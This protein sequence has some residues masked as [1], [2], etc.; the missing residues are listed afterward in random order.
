MALGAVPLTTAAKTR[1]TL[2]ERGVMMQFAKQSPILERLKLRNIG[3]RDY[4]WAR[5]TDNVTGPQYGVIGSG[6]QTIHT[7]VTQLSATMSYFGFNVDID[8][9]ELKDKNN[10]E[11]PRQLQ[12]KLATAQEAYFVTQQFF[13]GDPNTQ[14]NVV[15]TAGKTVTVNQLPGVRYA[16]D[17]PAASGL[18]NLKKDCGGVDISAAGISPTNARLL[19]RYLDQGIKQVGDGTG[20]GLVLVAP[21]EITSVLGDM[22]RQAGAFQITQDSFGRQVPMYGNVEIIDSGLSSPAKQIYDGTTSA[23]RVIGWET[24]AGVRDDASNFTSAY[25]LD[26]SED[27]ILGLE[28]YGMSVIDAGLLQSDNVT[29]RTTVDWS[30]GLAYRNPTCAYRF[31]DIKIK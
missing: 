26:F 28:Q 31:Y 14:V 22:M 20:K 27:G 24:A 2:I 4:R 10:F 9:R 16:L 3:T 1:Q 21:F 8:K 19:M 29:Y 7:D 17:N 11:D 13:N 5:V 6:Y 18:A 12:V 25:L 23:N 30:L 15:T